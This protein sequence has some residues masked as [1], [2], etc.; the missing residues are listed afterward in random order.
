MVEINGFVEDGYGAIADAFA[1]NWEIDGEV[2]AGFSLVHDG[3]LVADL[4]GGTADDSGRAY[5]ADTL[6]L[7]FSST[8]GVAAICLAMLAQAGELDYDAPV[9]SIWPEFAA[10]DKGDLP[11]SWAISHRVGL[12]S[13]DDPPPLEEILAVTPIVDALAAQAPL[14]EPDGSHGYH[15]ITY[16]WIAAEILRRVTGTRMNEWLQANVVEPLGVEFHMGLPESEHGRVAP[17]RNAPPPSDPEMLALMMS[18]M[19]PGTMGGRALSLDGRFNLVGENTFNRGDVWSS[20]IPGAAGITNARSLATI[21][22]ATVGDVGGVRL[23]DDATRE[24][25]T[26]PVTEGPDKSLV[27]ET[28]FGMGFMLPDGVLPLAGPRSFGHSGAGGSL[29]YADPDLGIG[30]GYVMNQMA[31]GLMGDPRATRLTEAVVACVS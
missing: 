4:T 10:A 23:L 16:G 5:D 30:Y 7:V 19:G 31:G 14:W 3:K 15:A 11:I 21:Y 13:V 20:E 2:G 25:A 1:T 18:V 6:Q 24:R 17:I 26:I 22:A 27:M 29:G 8:K 28:K 12:A 9:S